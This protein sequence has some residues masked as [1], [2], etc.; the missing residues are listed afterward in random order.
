MSAV[1]LAPEATVARSVVDA[2]NPW[3]GLAAFREGDQEFFRGREADTESLFRFVLRERLTV[4]FGLAGLGKTSLL[5]AGLFPRLREEGIFPVYIR[6]CHSAGSPPP[7]WQ[8]REAVSAAA[9]EAGLEGPALDESETLWESFHRQDAGFW[10]PRNRP[11]APLL[12]FDQFE[13]AFTLGRSDPS[14]AVTTNAFFVELADLVEGRP[15]LAVRQRCEISL[16]E[17]RR[18]SFSHHPYKVLLSLREDFLADLEGLRRS[19]PSIVHNRLRL[20]SLNGEQARRVVGGNGGKLVPDDVANQVVRFVA[21]ACDT[22]E[23]ALED[24]QVEPT[25]LSMAATS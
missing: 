6:I 13:E 1:M 25:L 19:M 17:A 16:E 3:P 4:L 15:P 8:V 24:L 11:V 10:T 20:R 14:R 18:Y 5:Q 2:E 21:G 9:A 23:I 12:I 22:R 7:A